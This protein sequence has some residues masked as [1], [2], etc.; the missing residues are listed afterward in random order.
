M[1][2]CFLAVLLSLMAKLHVSLDTTTSE[3]EATPEQASMNIPGL[4]MDMDALFRS[5]APDGAHIQGGPALAYGQG[6][7]NE[8]ARS[9]NDPY[10]DVLYGLMSGG[11]VSGYD[12]LFNSS[13]V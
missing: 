10:A 6:G 5:F 4:P 9:S 2:V 12:I 13:T 3:S 1:H 11:N 7:W 8:M